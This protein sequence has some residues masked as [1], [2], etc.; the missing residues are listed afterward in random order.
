MPEEFIS[1]A[2][3]PKAGTF[4]VSAMSR[5]EAGVPREFTWREQAYVVERLIETW[6]TSSADRG[7]MYLRRHWFRIQTTTGE[8]MVLYCQRQTKNAKRPKARWWLY[9]I[10]RKA[11]TGGASF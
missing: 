3:T 9:S 1:E 11:D 5:G 7:E 6:K 10:T 2:I 8:Q 4:D